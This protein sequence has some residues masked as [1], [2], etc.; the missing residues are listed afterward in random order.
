MVSGKS[1]DRLCD[2]VR[3]PVRQRVRHRFDGARPDFGKVG[4][5]VTLDVGRHLGKIGCLVEVSRLDL[6]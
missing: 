3:E 4:E 5:G 6:V 2:A 1:K